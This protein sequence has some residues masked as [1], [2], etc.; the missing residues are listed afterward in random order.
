MK[1]RFSNI[2]KIYTYILTDE[3]RRSKKTN[4]EKKEIDFLDPKYSILDDG[5]V[6]DSVDDL[7]LIFQSSFQKLLI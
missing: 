3:E 2:I 6:Y 7:I 4:N 1:V 5:S